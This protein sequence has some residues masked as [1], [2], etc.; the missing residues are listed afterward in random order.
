[1]PSQAVD[2]ICTNISLSG[3]ILHCT[4]YVC[5]SGPYSFGLQES[6]AD[7]LDR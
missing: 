5:K 4:F 6:L 1:M 2:C 3:H 7:I